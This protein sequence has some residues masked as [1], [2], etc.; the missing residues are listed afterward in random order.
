M[1]V[2]LS[3]CVCVCVGVCVCVCVC[4]S[5]CVSIPTPTFEPCVAVER[6]TLEA[7]RGAV[8]PVRL[9]QSV[10]RQARDPLQGV[11]VLHQAQSHNI[12]GCKA[13]HACMAATF[14]DEFVSL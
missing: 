10:R 3:V 8:G 14:S 2:C 6:V 5:V 7:V 13:E 4:L 12:H 9:H 11:D 1:C